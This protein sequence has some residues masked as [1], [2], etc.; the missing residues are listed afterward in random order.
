MPLSATPTREQIERLEAHL[1]QA[2]KVIGETVIPTWHSWA[3]GLVARTIRIDAG[4]LLTGGLHRSEHLNVCA[5]DITVW[6]EGGMRRLTGYHVLPSQAGAKRVGMAHATT[7]WTSIHLNPDNVRDV[8]AL[9]AM[10]IDDASALQ[11]RRLALAD[12]EPLEI[13]A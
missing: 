5:G 9:E 13:D 4:C 11:S 1:L 7:Y 10:L 2:A 6:T 8:A 3:D 12:A